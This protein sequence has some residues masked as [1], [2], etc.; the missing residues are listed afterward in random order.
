MYPRLADH[1]ASELC[2]SGEALTIFERQVLILLVDALP[3]EIHSMAISSLKE[4]AALKRLGGVLSFLTGLVRSE[5]A[6]SIPMSSQ[7]RRVDARMKI[8]GCRLPIEATL[9]VRYGR[10]TSL[11]FD[12]PPPPERGYLRAVKIRVGRFAL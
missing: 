8:V 1:W 12:S 3:Y 4:P 11:S 7:T 10:V 5:D 9:I 6:S 2:L